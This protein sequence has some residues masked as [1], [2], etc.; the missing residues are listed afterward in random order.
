MEQLCF[1]AKK[2]PEKIW[3]LKQNKPDLLDT[4]KQVEDFEN[5]RSQFKMLKINENPT[6]S[7]Y[8][9]VNFARNYSTW[10]CCL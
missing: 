6:K 1:E 7:S 10:K 9:T 4:L 2:N 3:D 8:K 5:K